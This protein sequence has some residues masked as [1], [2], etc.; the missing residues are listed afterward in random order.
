MY[1]FISTDGVLSLRDSDNMRAFSIVE[2]ESGGAERWLA[3]LVVD[4]AGQDFWLDAN[5]VVELSG[6]AHDKA[7]VGQFWD[8]LASVEA[9]GYSDMKTKRVKAHVEQA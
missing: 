4:T 1:I 5:A 7:W 2:E 9:Y 3:P 8:M 6:K